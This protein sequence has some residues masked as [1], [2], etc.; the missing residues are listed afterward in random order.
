MMQL[1]KT[2]RP[3]TKQMEPTSFAFDFAD[4]I[5]SGFQRLGDQFTGLSAQ[6]GRFV[7][8]LLVIVVAVTQSTPLP[9]RQV[10]VFVAVRGH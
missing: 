4:S 8:H 3:T 9:G 6:L 2:S 10:V 7:D 5:F 1:F